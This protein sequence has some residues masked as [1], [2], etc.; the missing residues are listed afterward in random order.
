[1]DKLRDIYLSVK[2]PASFGSVRSLYNEAKKRRLNVTLSDVRRFLHSQ[3]TYTRHAL[4]KK[5]FKHAKVVAYSVDDAWQADLMYTK[6]PRANKNFNYVLVIVDVLSDYIWAYPLKSK[7]TEEVC[8]KFAQLFKSRKPSMLTTDSGSGKSL[9]SSF[10]RDPINFFSEFRSRMFE[11]LMERGRVIHHFATTTSSKANVAEGAIGIIKSKIGKYLTQSGKNDWI[12]VFPDI[13]D[14]L[15][16]RPLRSLG[17]RAPSQINY[18]NQNEIFKLRFGDK[19]YWK[20]PKKKPVLSVGDLVRLVL[21]K[22]DGFQKASEP[23]YSNEIYK[24]SKIYKV[25]PV[26][27]YSVKDANDRAITG[28]YYAS[29]LI[30]VYL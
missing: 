15:N 23:Q 4:P 25:F 17:G 2:D 16:D 29:Q 8:D 3:S 21:K 18:E 10:E 27:M 24:I 20:S 13:I 12:T 14:S 7:N 19:L 11:T 26:Y 6:K 22:A 5:R 30:R 9:P 1:M 28:R